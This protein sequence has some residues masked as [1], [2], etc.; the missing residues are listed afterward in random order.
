MKTIKINKNLLDV[1][2]GDGWEKWTR[3]LLLHKKGSVSFRKIGGV[4]LSPGDMQQLRNEVK[5]A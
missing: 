3:F 2:C 4:A 1:F 5:H